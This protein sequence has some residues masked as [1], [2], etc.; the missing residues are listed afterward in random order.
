MCLGAGFTHNSY[1]EHTNGD[2]VQKSPE[3][4]GRVSLPVANV[5]EVQAEPPRTGRVSGSYLHALGRGAWLRAF[6][7]LVGC[8]RKARVRP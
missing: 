2:M 8:F 4:V 1:S 5:V 6:L 7:S 3:A